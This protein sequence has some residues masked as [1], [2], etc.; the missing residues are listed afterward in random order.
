MPRDGGTVTELE[1]T[2]SFVAADGLRGG[3]LRDESERPVGGVSPVLELR[4]PAKS[5]LSA[6]TA[7]VRPLRKMTP[8]TNYPLDIAVHIGRAL[9]CIRHGD[10]EG[11]AAALNQAAALRRTRSVG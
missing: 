8:V 6:A 10:I 9:A 7:H 3:S 5:K 11:A 1:L 4:R 2:P